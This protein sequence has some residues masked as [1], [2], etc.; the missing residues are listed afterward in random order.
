MKKASHRAVLAFDCLLSKGANGRVCP[1]KY[2]VVLLR[3][4]TLRMLCK[5]RST[6]SSSSLAN[7]ISQCYILPT[8]YHVD[9]KAKTTLEMWKDL[10]FFRY[11]TELNS[12]DAPAATI[13]TVQHPWAFLASRLLR[14]TGRKG[15]RI[16][17]ILVLLKNESK[18]DNVGVELWLLGIGLPLFW[19]STVILQHVVS[20]Q[21][22]S[23]SFI[24]RTRLPGGLC[25][26]CF[27]G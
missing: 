7:L 20:M 26:L 6:P 4:S 21:R 8:T 1:A 24:G 3:N 27:C 18:I 14:K 23:T 11:F 22:D 19:F 2:L 9:I 12:F 17:R 13:A 25:G 15:L 16:R 5:K 10:W